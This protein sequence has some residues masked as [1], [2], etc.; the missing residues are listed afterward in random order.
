MMNVSNQDQI[1]EVMEAEVASE[2]R[3]A[4]QAK[5]PGKRGRPPGAKNKPKF[6][7]QGNLIPLKKDLAPVRTEGKRRGRPKGSVKVKPVVTVFQPETSQDD[8]LLPVGNV[9]A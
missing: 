1:A 4:T 2:G 9:S 3:A 6:D 7:D 8:T 5:T